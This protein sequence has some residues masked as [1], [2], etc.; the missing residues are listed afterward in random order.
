[1]NSN[2]TYRNGAS[3]RAEELNQ[4]YKDI[5]AEYTYGGGAVGMAR[6][7][8]GPALT[9]SLLRRRGCGCV[10]WIAQVPAV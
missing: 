10:G 8:P 3:E 9:A 2:E 6:T 5:I 7:R 1:M 4:Q